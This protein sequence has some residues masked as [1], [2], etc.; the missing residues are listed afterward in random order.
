MQKNK[1]D[2][3]AHEKT[4]LLVAVTVLTILAVIGETPLNTKSRMLLSSTV[5]DNNS[6]YTGELK[7]AAPI[8]TD[9]PADHPNATALS[10]L[11]GNHIMGGYPDG[12]FGPDKSINRAELIK[13]IIAVVGMPQSTD[14]M[15]SCFF[16]VKDEWFAPYVCFAK[17]KNWVSG[18]GNGTFGPANNV[19]RAEAIKMIV[20]ASGMQLEATPYGSLASLSPNLWYAKYV[21][22]ADK[23]GLMKDWKDN[24]A[25]NLTKNA[26]RI[27]IAT[28]IYALAINKV[29]T[30]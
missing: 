4:I 12:S 8:F 10:Y 11:K 24:T 18:Y 7:P 5:A 20:S 17:T 14:A 9:I 3:L 30:I 21:W 22:T 25:E 13:T 27:D 1:K 28:A 19:T 29:P 15:K 2:G 6:A 16:D 26:T 23:N